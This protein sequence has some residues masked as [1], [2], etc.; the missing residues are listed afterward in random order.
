MMGS[1]R[2]RGG[3]EMCCLTAYRRL[4]HFHRGTVRYFKRKFWKRHRRQA[5]RDAVKWAEHSDLYRG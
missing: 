5:K 1:R 2:T 4:V 3:G